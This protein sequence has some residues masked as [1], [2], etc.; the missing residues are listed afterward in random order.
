MKNSQKKNARAA[1][2]FQSDKHFKKGQTGAPVRQKRASRAAALTPVAEKKPPMPREKKLFISLTA[3]VLVLTLSFLT[4]GSLYLVGAMNRVEY[5]SIYE[6]VALKNYVRM[7]NSDYLGQKVDLSGVYTAPYTLDDMDDAVKELLFS[8][9]ELIASGVKSAVIGYGDDVQC[10]VLGAFLVNDDGTLGSEILPGIF[11]DKDYS[12]LLSMTVGKGNTGFGMGHDDAVIALG[13]KPLDTYRVIRT[14]GTLS[15][16]EV[17]AVSYS[18]VKSENYTAA[19]PDSA[20]WS[21]SNTVA[22]EGASRVDLSK[23]LSGTDREKRL[24]NAI[25]ENCKQVEEPFEFVL[26]NYDSNGDNVPE[27]AVKYTVTVHFVVEEENY[28]DVIF[29]VPENHYKETEGATKEYLAL[30]GKKIALRTIFTYMNDY[31]VPTAKADVLLG[32]DEGFTTDKTSDADVLAAFKAYYL[33]KLNAELAENQ[34]TAY[35]EETVYQ[36]ASVLY[37]K[38]AFGA[39]VADDESPY[40]QGTLEAAYSRAYSDLSSAYNASGFAS[41]GYTIDQYASTLGGS[42]SQTTAQQYAYNVAHFAVAKELFT[43]YV[44]QDARLR[45]SDELLEKTYGEYIA[46]LT[47]AY[48]Q[49]G[50]STEYNEAYFVEK[51]GKDALYTEARAQAVHQLVGEYLLENNKITYGK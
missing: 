26:E 35:L 13:I 50:D 40:P 1:S 16:G 23:L 34:K 47:E 25:V 6:K 31:E 3:L 12:S 2:A 18:A 49:E 27:K 28:R 19:N 37:N 22:V 33:E 9:R 21:Q 46:S 41:Y 42:G 38:N 4:L 48:T 36:L 10:Y 44:F 14:H 24:A 39:A 29:T 8:K 5:G 20:S 43:Y 32:L 7:S 15:G 30:N 45:V 11:A 51:Y 17:I